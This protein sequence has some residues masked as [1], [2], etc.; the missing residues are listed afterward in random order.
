MENHLENSI[1]EHDEG[2]WETMEI[3][4]KGEGSWRPPEKSCLERNNFESAWADMKKTSR[5]V[6]TC[7]KILVC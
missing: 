7:S 5:Q 6:D 3:V 4:W 1:G 2:K